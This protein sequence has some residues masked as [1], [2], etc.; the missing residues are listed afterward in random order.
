MSNHSFGLSG[1]NNREVEKA[2]KQFGINKS[3]VKKQN[4]FLK[5]LK[6]TVTEPMFVLLVG[7]ASIYFILGQT[8]EAFF[9]TGAI[10]LVSAISFY[11]DNRSRRALEALKKMTAPNAKGIRNSRLVDILTTE[12][13]M[14]DYLLA[15]EGSLIAADGLVIQSNDFSVNESMLTG[16]SFSVNK[17]VEAKDNRV[18][19]G[20]LAVSGQAIFEVTAIGDKT[21]LGK[22]GQS[23][24]NVKEEKTPL[25]IQIGG[26]VKKM[27]LVG[28][29]VFLLVWGINYFSSKDFLDSLLKG[30]TLAMSILP[31][32]IPVAFSTFMA[33]GAWRLMKKGIVVKQTK[34]VESLGA[35][36]VI[37]TDKTGTITENRMT[38]AHLV[39]SGGSEF[40][41]PV[42]WR[43]NAAANEVIKFAMFG[44]ETAPFD[45]MEQALHEA[46]AESVSKD[47]RLEFKMI[48]EYPL[49]GKPPMMTHVFEGKESNRIIAAKGAPEAIL[50]VSNL[51]E[52]SRKQILSAVETLARKGFRILGVAKSNFT[53]KNF[54]EKQQQLPF[55]FVGLVA[56]YDP[57]KANIK[58]VFQHFYDAGISVKIITGDNALTTSAI[59][60][61]AGFQGADRV[62]DGVDLVKMTDS[63]LEAKVMETN[64]FTRMFPEAK[65]RIINALKNSQQVVAMT[66]DGVNDGP[67]LKAAH[68]GIAMGHRGSEL[69]RS[70]ASLILTDDDLG[71]MVDAIASG[72]HIYTNLK[73]AIQY[74]ISIHIP[75][76]VTVAGPLLL[77]WIYPNIFTPVHVIFLELI[78]G[79]TCSIIYE[80][81]PQEA[82]AMKLPPRKMAH[83]FFS[84]KELLASII[85]G[86]VIA[87]GTLLSYQMALRSGCSEDQVRTLVFITLIGAN[88]FLT[89]ENRSFYYSL[90]H[91]LRYKNWMLVSIITFTILMVVLM[92]SISPLRDFFSFAPVE[93]LLLAKAA[94]LGFFSVLWFEG[95]KIYVRR[96]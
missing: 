41:S 1:L 65:L 95:Y 5:S 73:K 54:P 80:S 89:L 48:H 46:Y 70:A 93:T 16:E 11:Q 14:G 40:L 83:T 12:I 69:A 63:E 67:A 38:L 9:M 2:R 55:V 27:A 34:T 24:Q 88:I 31:E 57:P 68:I 61:Q 49:D 91:T 43:K 94:A 84:A 82:N 53:G 72:R 42:D 74:I 37:C 17:S 25:Q 66:G 62:L 10:L 44:S 15:E 13:V 64:I 39:V 45:P 96:K 3:F 36:T 29:V 76:I 51:D 52:A 21:E 77:G 47:E 71:K 26:F 60:G 59:A 28:A 56:F 85:Q 19:Q 4:T 79:P 23:I 22:I 6:D 87:A 30:L 20:T 92:L 33:L 32:E 8:Q 58:E 86:I 7:A 78:M 90:L 35:A 50:S 75:I 18:F 81:E